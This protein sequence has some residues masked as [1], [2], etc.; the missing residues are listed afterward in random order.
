[1]QQQ[2]NQLDFG[3][4]AGGVIE[5][6]FTRTAGLNNNQAYGSGVGV[7]SQYRQN[8]CKPCGVANK[9]LRTMSNLPL[10]K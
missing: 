10:K 7:Q 5:N 6:P 3:R 8:S 2:P 4:L 1:M 9:R